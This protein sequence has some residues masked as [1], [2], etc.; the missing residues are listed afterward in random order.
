MNKLLTLP[1]F[2]LLILSMYSIAQTATSLTGESPELPDD[3]T[4]DIPEADTQEFNIWEGSYSI[5][6]IL[7]AIAVGVLAGIR[8]FDTGLSDQAQVLL[9]NSILFMTLWA[10]L[11]A[12]A[13]EYMFQNSYTTMLWILLTTIYVVGLGMH[14]TNAE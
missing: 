4:V 5:A 14:M 1:L 3:V 8:I 10:C 6:I 11:S 7:A 13:Y 12:V 2:F 9:F